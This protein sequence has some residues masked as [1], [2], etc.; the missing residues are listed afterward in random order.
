[1]IGPCGYLPRIVP[2]M[3][4]VADKIRT[5]RRALG[6]GQEAFG[7]LFGVTQATVSRWEKGFSV[8]ANIRARIAEQAGQT[9]G[10]FFHSTAGPRLVPVVGYVSA[11]EAFEPISDGEPIDAF[12]I[13][14]ADDLI[15]VLV[16]GDSMDP[17]YRTGDVVIGRQV[18]GREMS[19]FIDRDCIVMTK[20]GE[21]YLKQLKKPA[22]SKSGSF[23]LRAY[24]DK[25]GDVDDVPLD[26][27]APVIWIHRSI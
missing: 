19:K 9:E 17:V 26:W 2:G 24:N 10:E 25:Y 16:R 20:A 4:N 8:Q 23:R 22:S 1:M 12:S 18:R 6:L 3:T 5:L 13:D 27:V 11:G 7:D 15:A 14:V 21:G